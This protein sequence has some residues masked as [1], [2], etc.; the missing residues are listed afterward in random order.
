MKAI[1]NQRI[2]FLISWLI[3]EGY[4]ASQEALGRELGIKSKSYLSQ[5]VNGKVN[6]RDF[7][8]KLSKLDSRI[9]VEWVLTGEGEMLK[10]AA[11]ST[12]ESDPGKM[13]PFYDAQAAAGTTYEMDMSSVSRPSKMIRMGDFLNDSEAAIQVFGNSMTPNYPAG[14]IVGTKLLTDS[15]IEPGTVYVIETR[16]NRYLKRLYYCEGEDCFECVSDNHM[17]SEEGSRKGKPC[18][19]SFKIPCNEVVRLHRVTGVIKRN[20]L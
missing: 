17:L 7:I 15:F 10:S 5:L 8:N 9:N 4:A 12:G 2:K 16:D 19:P 14:C 13:I 6:N 1:D 11:S 18:Y 3:Q 20:I